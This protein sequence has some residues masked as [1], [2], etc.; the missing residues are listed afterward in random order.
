MNYLFFFVHPSK[1]HMFRHTINTLIEKGHN[2]EVLI[3][4]KDVLEEL[5]RNEGWAYKNIFPEGRKMKGVHPYISSFINLFRTLY[6]LFKYTKGKKFD[7][8]ITDDLLVYI[9][10][11][12]RVPT[13]VFC[14]DDINVVK[15]FAIVLK[16]ATKILSPDITNLGS[17]S[18]KKIGFP[19]YKELAYLHPNVFSPDIEIV[20]KFNPTL[21]PYF[22]IRLVLVKSYHDTGIKGL[23]DQQ[24]EKLISLLEKHGNVYITSERPLPERYAK[25]KLQIEPS[26]IAHV[27]KFAKLFIG[28]SQTMTS[29]AAVLGTPSFR[30][31]DFVGKISVMEEKVNKYELSY[32]YPPSQFNEMLEKIEELLS[33]KNLEDIFINK[34]NK[35]LKEKIDLS[36]FMIWLFESF[37]E[38][39]FSKPI[40][41]NPYKLQ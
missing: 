14:D 41:F 10:K 20:K 6:R 26:K 9:G 5:V 7:L 4:S 35:M 25:Y 27:L 28:D 34:K 22:I 16:L 3:T 29:E 23:S 19:G 18:K 32:N 13:I 2:V 31:N 38:I 36:S 15:K 11:L 39:D 1:F 24:V 17:F 40:D 30:C 21:K 12:K 8:F 33:D 37:N